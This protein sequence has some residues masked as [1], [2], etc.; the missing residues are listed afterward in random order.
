MFG[1]YRTDFQLNQN[2][3]ATH[4]A[5]NQNDPLPFIAKLDENEILFMAK[6]TQWY[7]YPYWA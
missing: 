3:V 5:D 2:C 6:Y 1:Y 4:V 7:K